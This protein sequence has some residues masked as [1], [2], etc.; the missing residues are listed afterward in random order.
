MPALMPNEFCLTKEV[1]E[2]DFRTPN[3]GTFVTPQSHS[4]HGFLEYYD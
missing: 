2:R 1:P 3:C 4:I